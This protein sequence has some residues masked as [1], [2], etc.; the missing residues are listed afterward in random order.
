[1][2]T[3]LVWGDEV[4]TRDDQRNSIN[5]LCFS[6]DG[7]KLVVAVGNRVLVYDSKDG[8]LLHSLRGHKDTVYT[9]DWSGDG[10]RFASGG[11]D[12]TVI[13]WN[14]KAEGMLK[15]TH[16]D[17]VQR[18]THDPSTGVLASCTGLD[19]GLWSQEEKSVNKHKVH[20]KI[21]SAAWALAG[22]LLALGFVDGKISI[23]DRDG[24][25]KVSMSRTAPVWC[26]AWSTAPDE[27]DLLVV[28]CWDQTLSF[29]KSTGAQQNKDR[30]LDYNPCTLGYCHGGD[31]IVI[32][33]SDRKTTLLTREGV[34][35][36]VVCAKNGWVWSAKGRPGHDSVA[37]G[38]DDGS[39]ELY[40]LRF[41][42]VHSLYR[43]RYAFRDRMTDV[44]V[45]HL[46]S[47]QKVRGHVHQ[48]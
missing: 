7:R 4:P 19:F 18:V 12:R 33:G 32:G 35:I 36:G 9:V 28:G 29:Y 6:P 30:K 43:D 22:R 20:A 41:T 25:E 17:S 39:I 45:Q 8:N 47:E 31:Y 37:V 42:N 34:K 10:K 21:L 27:L 1:M 38:C 14:S 24:A 3:D 40:R 26:L 13:I 5:D 11:A 15:Y 46:V 44:I 16:N 23:R 2:R 48:A